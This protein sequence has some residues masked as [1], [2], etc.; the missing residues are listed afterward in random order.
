MWENSKLFNLTLKHFSI[1]NNKSSA[2]FVA[3]ITSN[4]LK[5]F[6]MISLA[7]SNFFADSASSN[8]DVL[9]KIDFSHSYE[10]DFPFVTFN[11]M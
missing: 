10:F 5:C 11:F 7:K 8:P 1:L 6:S 2:S 4:F 9:R 3:H